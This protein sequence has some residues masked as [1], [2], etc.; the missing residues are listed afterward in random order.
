M[1][2][3]YVDFVNGNNASAGTSWATAI[4]TIAGVTS[5]KGLTG[6]DTVRVAKTP[7]KVSIGNGTWTTGPLPISKGV[8]AAT[9]ATPIQ[10]TANSHG[11]VTGDVVTVTG[12]GGNTAAN[13]T[14]IVTN[15]GINTVTLDG[16]VGNGTYTSGGSINDIN[17]RTVKLATSPIKT[18][19]NC[20]IDFT[21]ANSATVNAA[22]PSKQGTQAV[23]VT[24][25]STG[26]VAN[27]RYAYFTLP[28]GAQDFS[29]Y[30]ELSFWFQHGNFLN[31]N[32]FRICLCSDTL[33]V[34][35]V[36][37]FL[38]TA[39]AV[40]NQWNPVSL[41]RVGGGNLGASIQSVAIYTG[42][43][44][45]NSRAI[46]FDNIFATTT[47]GIN[48]TGLISPVASNTDPYDN[49]PIQSVSDTLV[50]I[51]QN[52][53]NTAL[54]GKGYYGT[55]QTTTTYYRQ[56]NSN[57][58][59]YSVEANLAS[60]I[61]PAVSPT[62]PTLPI[63]FSGGWNTSTDT[64]DGMTVIQTGANNH[65]WNLPSYTYLENMG[66]RGGQSAFRY[67]GGGNAYYSG[68]KFTNCFG[69]STTNAPF[70]LTTLTP[71]NITIGSGYVQ[72]K[73]INCGANNNNGGGIFAASLMGFE[74][75]GC[76]T[77]NS[78]NP[79]IAIQNM[80]AI[81]LFV[82][83]CT[84]NNTT[85]HGLFLGSV[86]NATVVNCSFAHNTT[87]SI[88]MNNA[89]DCNLYDITS[90][91]NAPTGSPTNGIQEGGGSRN[92][93]TVN[94]TSNETVPY[95]AVANGGFSFTTNTNSNGLVEGWSSKGWIQ[96]D[97]S[98]THGSA[99]FSWKYINIGPGSLSAL[100]DSP[101]V[102]DIAQVYVFAGQSTTIKAWFNKSNATDIL[103]DLFIPLSP[104]T[105]LANVSQN[106]T[107]TTG[108]Q[109]VSVTF[110]PAIT[111]VVTVQARF[112][113][114]STAVAN[115]N[116]NCFVSD[117]TLP[118]GVNTAN[119]SYDNLGFPWAQNQQIPDTQSYATVGL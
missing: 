83:D 112:W 119:L 66:V 24:T 107:N 22:T 46:I 94:L 63:T 2:T 88:L 81:P 96:K 27:T 52:Y 33:G 98:T 80:G 111:G 85:G 40:Q 56:P 16:S 50:I 11:L 18:V 30:Q 42:T 7:D 104:I 21:A 29:A 109:E 17:A 34:T 90:N 6:G 89:S 45:A 43:D 28:G 26:T 51:D 72:T 38:I 95:Q 69:T 37:N 116:L 91:F 97:S 103:A 32:S 79:G 9:N 3:F 5:A 92:N 55:T 73:T 102:L 62:N 31:N 13:G 68:A 12:V 59:L 23:R 84:S 117:L 61:T 53:N 71:T 20:D 86:N 70:F 115:N 64:Q 35:V 76:K 4:Q 36:D 60:I 75:I 118:A 87:G 10:I 65:M 74:M 67:I 19:S 57:V 58:N 93:R 44:V 113:V 77:N 1:A 110:T 106:A 39:G 78:F 8:T 100:S 41:A 48:L 105:T 47:G 108:W 25:P 14:W 99:T 15:T 114:A 101:A 82:S 49:Y 54:N